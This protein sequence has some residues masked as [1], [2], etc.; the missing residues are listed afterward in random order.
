MSRQKNF[1]ARTYGTYRDYY[2]WLFSKFILLLSLIHGTAVVYGFYWEKR[3]NLFNTVSV[4]HTVNLLRCQI[5]FPLIQTLQRLPPSPHLPDKPGIYVGYLVLTRIYWYAFP[6]TCKLQQGP[7]TI[8]GH[9]VRYPWSAISDWAW[10]RNFRYRTE[11]AESDIL[12]DIGI[13]FYLI[14]D[15]RLLNA[16]RQ[17]QQLS[18]IALAHHSKG[19]GFESASWNIFFLPY[20]ISEWALMS[21]PKHFRYRN[22][23]FQSDIFVSD[24]GATDVVV[25]YRRHW[26]RRRCPPMPPTNL[27]SITFLWSRYP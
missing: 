14:S 16:Y 21:I 6:C 12:S 8:G 27:Q 18:V 15:I 13:N 25:G 26:D 19:R 3:L 4:I 5:W 2:V 10:Y 7:P 11:R 23:I 24:I 22:D 9:L 1:S 20:R 17:I